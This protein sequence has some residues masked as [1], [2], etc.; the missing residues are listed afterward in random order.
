MTR[1]FKV[2]R[3]LLAVTLLTVLASEARA[4][5]VQG[6]SDVF[7]GRNYL[8]VEAED[9]SSLSDTETLGNGFAI[10]S[11]EN[12]VQS[13][14]GLDILPANSNVSGTAL[15]D[16]LGDSYSHRDSATWEVQFSQAGTYQFYP[17]I[18]LY[19]AGGNDNYGNEDSIWL[20][21]SFNANSS[22]DWIGY[23]GRH[24]DDQLP[25]VDIPIPGE[26]LDPDGWITQ[27]GD[28]EDDGRYE[29]TDWLVK[30]AGVI[31]PNTHDPALRNG[32]FVWYWKPTSNNIAADGAWLGNYGFKT[33]YIVTEDQVGEVLT[34]EIG[35][36]EEYGL[37]DGFLFIQDDDTDLL[38]IYTQEELDGV[39]PVAGVPEDLNNDGFVDGLDLGIL[40]GNFEQTAG[41]DGGEL[42]G[43]DPVDGL[44]LGI[45]LGAWNP[46]PGLGGAT[47]PEPTTLGL[48]SIALAAFA[49]RR[50]A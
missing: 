9:Y 46:P 29:M 32:N 31:N 11:K 44:D 25:D 8:Y 16:Q 42:D 24:Y 30:S 7:N 47:V 33:E 39:L 2:V 14:Q 34:F 49:L 21:P 23:E 20:P 36:R 22:T 27:V 41:P 38:D 12:P 37:I 6:A 48:M 3:Q 18:S 19:E 50:S 28:N 10:A 17:R 1:Q 40:L 26:S 43:T 5:T 45:L 13:N 35:T 15:L 4:V